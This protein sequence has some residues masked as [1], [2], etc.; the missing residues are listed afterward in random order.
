MINKNSIKWIV[1]IASVIFSIIL[2]CVFEKG[3]SLGVLLAR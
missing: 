1:I 3:E 2:I